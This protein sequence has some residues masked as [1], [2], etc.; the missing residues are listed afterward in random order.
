[1][2]IGENED[3]RNL[4]NKN[5]NVVF[6]RVNNKKLDFRVFFV[7][8]RL[9]QKLQVSPAQKAVVVVFVDQNDAFL[10]FD[11]RFFGNVAVFAWL[12]AFKRLGQKLLVP[13]VGV[14]LPLVPLRNE[15]L[16]PFLRYLIFLVYVLL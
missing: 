16:D 9:K 11:K 7:G 3:T 15:R 8:F 14:D 4:L 2:V 10:S 12:K 13:R 5:G 6:A 1:M